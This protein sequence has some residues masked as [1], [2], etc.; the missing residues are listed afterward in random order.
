LK[1]VVGL[2]NPGRR[3]AGTRHN[4][5]FRI[6]E[7]LAA[8]H[9]IAIDADRFEGRLGCGRIR[10]LDVA[11]LE[12][13]TYMNASGEAVVE[14]LRGLPVEDVG[15][16]LLLA[17]DDVDLPFGRI[18]LRASGGHG[19]HGGMRDVIELLGREDFARLR[20][21]VGRS[22]RFD[23]TRHVLDAFSPDEQKA[24]PERIER[25]AQAIESFLLEG[26]E[27]AMNRFNA[28]DGEA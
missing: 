24:L 26:V 17:Y 3:Y 18:R 25:A 5:G 22:E 6:V 11:L 23:T 16:D 13:H 28:A 14:A 15:R 4:V 9:A 1:L 2:G 21:G 7:C 20:F 19:G 10:D 27:A 12:P 8:R